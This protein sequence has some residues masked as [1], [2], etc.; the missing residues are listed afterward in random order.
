MP[1]A[2]TED[3]ESLRATALRWAQTHCP[4]PVPRQVAEARRVRSS[5]PRPGRRWPR[6]AGS[7]STCARSRGGR[8]SRW[9]SW[10][11]CSRSS[12]TPSSPGR[13]CPRCSSRPRSPA[14]RAGRRPSR[15]SGCADWP[16]APSRQPWRWVPRRQPWRTAD[17]GALALEGAV[18][19]VL[20]LPTARL[21]LVP[22]DYGT[23]TGWLVFDR[24][25]LGECGLRRGA[26]RRSTA[27]AP[28]GS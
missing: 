16:T 8:A 4:A 12:D 19:P 6:R 1:I 11:S 2:V 10:P 18:R 9:P 17:D 3:H 7:A 24:L 13:C 26:P 23:G 25:A 20:G 5:C 15:R 21:V 14:R 22:L 28:W 27:P